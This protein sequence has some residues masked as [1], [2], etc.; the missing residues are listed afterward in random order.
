MKPRGSSERERYKTEVAAY[1]AAG[2]NEQIQRVVTAVHGLHRMLEQ[3][4][5]TQLQD[6]DLTA[7]EWA[8][9]S[10]IATAQPDEVVTPSALAASAAIAPSSMT[11]RLDRM[12]ERGLINREPDETN[13][14]RIVVSLTSAGWEMFTQVVRDS[15]ALESD[16]LRPLTERQREQLATLLERAIAGID[17]EIE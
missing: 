17:E 11:H 7:G 5:T 14:T 1:V 3:W 16:V 4:Y 13:R 2:G 9:I 8:V 12:A 15:E 10:Q 6:L